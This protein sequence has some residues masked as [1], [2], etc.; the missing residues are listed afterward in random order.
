MPEPPLIFHGRYGVPV[1]E[2]FILM[3]ANKELMCQKANKPPQEDW[4]SMG[5]MLLNICN[6]SHNNMKLFL[7]R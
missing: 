4:V 6:G 7:Y 5:L 1:S 2:S 3:S